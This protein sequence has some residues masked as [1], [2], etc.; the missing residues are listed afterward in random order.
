VRHAAAVLDA[1]RGAGVGHAVYTSVAGIADAEVLSRIGGFPAWV[2]PSA[3]AMLSPADMPGVEATKLRSELLLEGENKID[4]GPT[5]GFLRGYFGAKVM[6]E[7]LV[8]SWG[9]PG[10]STETDGSARTWTV[11]RPAWFMTN[12]LAPARAN[13]WPEYS[14]SR[15]VLRSAIPFDARMMLVDPADIGVVAA[16][17]LLSPF[18]RDSTPSLVGKIVNIGSEALTLTEVARNLTQISGVEVRFEHVDEGEAAREVRAGN[19][20][21]DAQ[22]WHATLQNCFEP[23]ELAGVLLREPRTFEEFLTARREEVKT[24]IG[25]SGEAL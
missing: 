11:L 14:P 9:H 13:Y 21:R 15:R 23:G 10:G 22:A 24:C 25:G 1:A 2:S 20:Q 5:R 8:R 19:V 16:R 7:E 4:D 12:F 17:A 18:G 6:I 3:A